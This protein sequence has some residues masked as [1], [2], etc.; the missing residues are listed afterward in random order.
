LVSEEEDTELVPI[1]VTGID[2]AIP[3]KGLVYVEGEG[4]INNPD[5]K[6]IV[7]SQ[8]MAQ[9]LNR[10]IGDNLTLVAPE[11]S[12]E[13]EIIGIADYPIESA[14]MEWQQLASFVG[15][16]RDAPEP[17]SYWEPLRI[18]GDGAPQD[19]DIDVW[20]VGVDET[21]GKYLSEAYVP[22][23]NGIIISQSLASAGGYE[24]GDEITLQPRERDVLSDIIEEE[25]SYP[26]LAI[27]NIT[28]EEQALF[29]RTAP[30]GVDM[31][32]GIIAMDWSQLAALVGLDYADITPETFRIDLA[33]PEQGF[34]D[35]IDSTRFEPVAVYTNEVGFADRVAQ[36]ILGI[37]VVMNLASLLMAVVGGIGLLTITMVGVWERQ[38]EIG[39][40]RTL[41]ATTAT[42]F[43][44]FLIEGII[45][46]VLAWLVG[47]PLS[48][49]LT[50][51]L[52]DTV[53]FHEVIRFR[54]SLIAPIAGLVGMVLVTVLATL[55][56]ALRA[57]KRTVSEILRYA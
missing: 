11:N 49:L 22:E 6:G 4:W 43:A 23:G 37:G 3:L 35:E 2:T 30:E 46:G 44:Q 31:D 13:F 26:I 7:I 21:V 24:V 52:L 41:G 25:K 56:P 54:Y 38:R 17:N 9:L 12:Q 20:A 55:Y 57:S 36:T 51:L 14:F 8:E 19:A 10:S 50:R 16:L 18:G 28:Q 42:V 33:A 53:P 15:T 1:I 34:L 32:N 48:Y 27:V 29:Q 40:M 5:R 47:I 45:I 39:V